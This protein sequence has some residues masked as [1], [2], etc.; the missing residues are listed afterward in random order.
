MKIIKTAIPDVLVF[1]PQ[2]HQDDRG[3]FME[4]WR[5]SQFDELNPN[6]RF[7]QDNQSQS[8]RGTLRGL[9]Y[10]R[11]H[12]QGKL[13]RVVSGNVFD[14]AIDLRQSSTTFTKWVGVELSAEN[15]KQLWIP[16]G[17]AHGFYVLSETAEL[18]YKCTDYYVS[19]DNHCILWNDPLI[20]IAWPL[21]DKTPLL[22]KNDRCGK[23]IQESDLFE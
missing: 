2:V 6:L 20:G 14:V 3:Y 1:E 9:H 12:P 17:F 22:S 11:M 13:A 10:Q 21:V 18:I 19:K 16:P 5:E 4:T 15:K 8:S 7:V 23:K